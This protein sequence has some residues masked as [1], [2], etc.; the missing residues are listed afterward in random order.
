MGNPR[1]GKLA[2]MPGKILVPLDF[3]AYSLSALNYSLAFAREFHAEQTLL[4]V[5]HPTFYFTGTDE[6]AAMYAELLKD[7]RLASVEQMN[8]LLKERPFRGIT[9]HSLIYAGDPRREIPVAATRIGTDLII[10]STHGRGGLKHALLGSIAEDV[11]RRAPCAV[12]VVRQV[13]HDFV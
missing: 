8:K 10:L 11:V 1:R 12:L 7:S 2:L 3:S 4:H 9:S 13:E 6:E 5:V